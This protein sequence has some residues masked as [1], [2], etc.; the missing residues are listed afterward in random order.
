[1]MTSSLP[2]RPAALKLMP[3]LGGFRREDGAVTIEAALWL[4]FFVFA[5]CLVA[6]VSLTFYGKTRTLDVMQQANRA[7][8][9]G[10][11]TSTQQTEDYIVAALSEISPNVQAQTGLENGLVYSVVRVPSSDLSAVGL[12]PALTSFDVVLTSQ[13]YVEN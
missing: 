3:S 12:F 9:A 6:D 13:M 8:S 1:M 5:L 7:Y 2:R 11:L 4:P 10:E